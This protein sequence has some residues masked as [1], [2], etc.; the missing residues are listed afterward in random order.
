MG[1]SIR[2][3]LYPLALFS[4][5]TATLHPT[6]ILQHF[7]QCILKM[8]Q[9]RSSKPFPDEQPETSRFSNLQVRFQAPKSKV[10]PIKAGCVFPSFNSAA[11][12]RRV[13]CKSPTRV[14]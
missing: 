11:R 14:A 9:H 5:H 12:I 7:I 4:P 1:A 2:C 3:L 13:I 8:D 10:L 6:N